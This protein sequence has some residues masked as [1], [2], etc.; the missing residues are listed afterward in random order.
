MHVVATAREL[1]RLQDLVHRYGTRIRT[2]RHDVRNASA[3]TT[4]AQI[5]VDAFERIDV[6]VNAA[7]SADPTVEDFSV[8][9]FT[10]PMETNLFGFAYLIDATLP[11]LRQQ[12]SGRIIEISP[13]GSRIPALGLSGY[14]ISKDAVE[15]FTLE[16]ANEVA[17]LG[18][19]VT[20]VETGSTHNTRLESSVPVVSQCYNK[21]RID[22]AQRAH[23]HDNQESNDPGSQSRLILSIAEMAEPPVRLVVGADATQPLA[24]T[25][26]ALAGLEAKWRD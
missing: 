9:S 3:A 10:V 25:V 19:K 11:I 4:A 18:I 24:D 26:Q 21:S 14:H 17:P 7:R 13:A 23:A 5:A 15:D 20:I 22:R 12:K 2:V 1:A 16:L 6:V 8:D